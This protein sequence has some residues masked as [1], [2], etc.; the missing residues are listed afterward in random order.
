MCGMK[1]FRHFRHFLLAVAAL[2]AAV[3]SAQSTDVA[4]ARYAAAAYPG[5]ELNDANLKPERK[6]PRWFSWFTGPSRPN[7]AGQFAYCQDLLK[8]E[9][10]SKAARQ[11]DALV[12]EWPT[13]PEAWRAQRQLADVQYEK[14]GDTEDAFESYRYL[15]DF[16]SLQCDYRA[17]A[18]RLYE[19]AGALKLEGKE[20]MFVR[21]ANTAG[22]RRFYEACVLRAPGA[23]WVPA[24]MLTIASLRVEE[25]CPEE[26]V[27]VYENLRSIHPASAEA[28]KSLLPEANARMDILRERSYNRARCLDTV[29]YLKMALRLCD[30]DDAAA[31]QACLEEADG[32]LAEEAYVA[33]KFYDSRMRTRESAVGAYE[34]FLADH[35]KGVRADEVRARLA[36]LKGQQQ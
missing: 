35:P 5:F 14:L 25:G 23:D 17:T 16:Y 10:W 11:L 6:E 8:A 26:A 19:L 1:E 13:A 32:M 22:V 34:A 18:D 20:V 7:A 12:R 28:R 29:N 36:E 9:D 31:V 3:A 24:A 30:P 4:G 33:A 2:A 15:L 27:K 21:F